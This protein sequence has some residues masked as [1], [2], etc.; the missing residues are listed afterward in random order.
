MFFYY[1]V[2]KYKYR[3]TL[4][5]GVLVA[6]QGK[7]GRRLMRNICDCDAKTIK[8]YSY[9]YT[10]SKMIELRSYPDHQQPNSIV[11]SSV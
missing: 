7:A 1:T 11:C 2:S 9:Y 3:S 10:G 6:P 5:I 8:V 4:A